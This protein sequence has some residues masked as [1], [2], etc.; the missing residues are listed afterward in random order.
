MYVYIYHLP[1]HL[2]RR[3]PLRPT[4]TPACYAT[5]IPRLVS[6]KRT[7]RSSLPASRCVV[8]ESTI[9]GGFVACCLFLSRNEHKWTIT[10]P[11]LPH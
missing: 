9:G 7:R 8:V 4:T 2:P 5:T 1:V 10:C 11:E 6:A 3:C